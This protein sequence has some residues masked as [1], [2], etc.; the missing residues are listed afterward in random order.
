MLFGVLRGADACAC[1]D[2]QVRFLLV[3]FLA[4]S[5]GNLT[6]T[7]AGGLLRD[8]VSPWVK[9]GWKC[10]TEL[11]RDWQGVM[12]SWGRSAPLVRRGLLTRC[13][14]AVDIARSCCCMCT[15]RCNLSI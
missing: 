5:M 1:R 14:V 7:R 8:S 11:L 12:N 9:R 3:S 15:P 6:Y 4:K 10:L 13:S 2:E